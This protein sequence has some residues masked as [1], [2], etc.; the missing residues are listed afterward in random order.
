MW[1][2]L[3]SDLY[4]MFHTKSF[5]ISLI[6]CMFVYFLIF[7]NFGIMS[8]TTFAMFDPKNDSF[9]QYLYYLP[10]SGI[11]VS[12]LLIFLSMFFSDEYNTGFH[13]NVYP[14]QVKK[15]AIVIERCIFTFLTVVIFY[16]CTLIPNVIY[17]LCNPIP[18]GDLDLLQY[19]IFLFVQI[20][21]LCAVSGLIALIIHVTKS[22]VVAVLFA[23][24][25]GMMFLYMILMGMSM[26]MF[27]DDILVRYTMYVNAG[28]LPKT[29]HWSTYQT[30]LL[31]L[32][33]TLI[34]YHLISYIVLKKKDIA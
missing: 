6:L 15:Y 30:P 2:S 28:M 13:K 12:I 8:D 26:F 20:L 3:K 5:Y 4:R 7:G 27:E 22:R 1:N 25:Y 33:G 23:I 19:L 24:G 32:I 31:V 10:K 11:F 21:F 14:L 29:F 34:L 16:I 17:Q 18:Y 9:I